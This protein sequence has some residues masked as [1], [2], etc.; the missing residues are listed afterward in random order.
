[1]TEPKATTTDSVLDAFFGELDDQTRQKFNIGPRKTSRADRL[2]SWR[3]RKAG[4][5]FSQ[6]LP[7]PEQ[8]GPP[9]AAKTPAQLDGRDW[10][11]IAKRAST[12]IGEDRVPAVAAGVTFYALLAMFPALTA[13]ISIYGLFADPQKIIDNFEMLSRFVPTGALNIILDQTTAIT[14]APQ[15]ALS[16]ASVLGLLVAFYSANGGTKAMISAMNIAWFQKEKRGF[17]RLNLLAMCFTVGGALLVVSMFSLIALLPAVFSYL[18]LDQYSTRVVSWLR[19][20]I[21]FTAVLFA[22][23]VFYRYGPSRRSARWHWIS[24]GAI[25][26]AVGLG[27]ASLLFS[28]YASNIANYNQT[29][30]SLGAV[31]GLMMWLWIASMVVIVGAEI[32][33]EVERQIKIEN[34][35]PVPGD[36]EADEDGSK[37]LA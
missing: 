22:L 29:Y 10:L 21:I 12:Q 36:P 28:W 25:F 9:D 8:V 33:S 2:Q 16:F 24:P 31:I 17:L 1:M 4:L 14:S 37:E 23:A 15:A 11:S 27:L 30:G 3:R 19:W 18:P 20:P 6:P 7:E 5:D 13:F 35:I 26:A 32:N 34:E